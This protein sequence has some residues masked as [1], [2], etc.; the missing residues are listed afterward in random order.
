M[1]GVAKSII[2]LLAAALGLFAFRALAFTVC[3]VDGEGLKPTFVRGDRVLVNRWSYGLRTG[4]PNGLFG[5]GRICRRMVE[6]GDIVAF[7]SPVD[8]DKG[9]YVCR[10]TAVPGDTLTLEDGTYLVPGLVTCANENY[11]WMEALSAENPVD[12]RLFGPVAESLI[13]G[14]VCLVLYNHDDTKTIFEGYDSSRTLLLVD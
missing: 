4:S 8:G 5:Y 2:A 6:R 11:Y 13:V 7:D 1:R 3:G 10:C 9:M 14:R 12:S